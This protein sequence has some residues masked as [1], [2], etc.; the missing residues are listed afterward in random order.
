RRRLAGTRWPAELPG[1]GWERG[2]PAGYLRELADYWRTEFDWRAVER[3]LNEIPQYTTEIDGA[4]VHFLHVR[5][6]EPAARPLL[7]THG[8]PSSFVE[9]LDVLGPLTDPAAYG[10]DPAD[11]FHVVVPSLPGFGF[12]GP[13]P[14]PGWDVTRIARA[15]AGLM[16]RLGYHRYLPQGSDFGAWI[17]VA[18][19]AL[20]AEHVAGAHVNFL[21]TPPPDDPARLAALT[22]DEARRVGRLGRFVADESGYMKIQATRPVTLSYALTDS[23]VGQLA[24]IV[25]K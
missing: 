5:S 17:T 11:A 14:E 25:E 4:T 22:E 16:D 23:P 9:Y 10:G 1:V 24:W 2:V 18:L 15:W 12:A 3:E 6:A 19:A 8:W 21:I 13:T 7:L 20:D